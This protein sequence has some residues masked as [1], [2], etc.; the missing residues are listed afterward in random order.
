MYIFNNSVK[1]IVIS[2]ILNYVL[3]FHTFSD[4]VHI[5]H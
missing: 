4:N 1:Y 5:G 2:E 3:Y